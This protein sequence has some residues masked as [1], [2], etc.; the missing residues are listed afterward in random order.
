MTYDMSDYLAAKHY[1]DSQKLPYFTFYP[2]WEKP[3]RAVIRHLPI[4][5]SEEDVSHG[6][7]E[8]GFDI[9]NVKQLSSKRA[10]ADGG[11][12][13]TNIPLFLVTLKRRKNRRKYSR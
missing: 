9:L 2:K 13:T 10:Q 8:L 7:V 3:I 11:T 6:F 12:Q 5:T 4:D 1:F